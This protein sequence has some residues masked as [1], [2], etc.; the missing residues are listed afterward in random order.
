MPQNTAAKAGHLASVFEQL[1]S[2]T[3]LT[4][5]RIAEATSLS[6]PTV[7]SLLEVLT[8]AGLAESHMAPEASGLG[9][10]ASHWSLSRT[11]GT[12]VAV[13]LLPASAVVTSARLDGSIIAARRTDVHRLDGD[14]RLDELVGLVSRAAAEAAEFGILRS[15]TL[16]NTGTVDSSGRV[17]D[18]TFIPEWIGL[19]LGEV[20]SDRLMAP[21]R[22][23]N[24]INCAAFGEFTARV[25]AGQ[26]AP[27]GDLVYVRIHQ[28]LVTGLVLAGDI[29]RG[30]TFSAG[31]FGLRFGNVEG[32]E[33]SRLEAIAQS[34][35][36][37]AAVLDPSVIVMSPSTATPGPLHAITERL[38]ER[39]LP[40]APH[41]AFEEP[42]LGQ[43]AACAGALALAMADA[44]RRLV[45]YT[46]P[47]RRGPTDPTPIQLAVK[48]GR[49]TI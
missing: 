31:E 41:R 26:L 14:G 10:P 37:M 25:D 46:S 28:G 20:L 27:D 44:R 18:S 13:D 38:A 23:E 35:G 3:A 45:P 12:V 47:A 8:R 1:L 43:G 33:P 15:V 42:L 16:A 49:H 39:L 9:R 5:S 40:T 6:R 7:R 17:L 4:I 48:D 21:V 34:I 32:D 36:A 29:H 19:S 24:D 22:V 2:A 11:A 30:I